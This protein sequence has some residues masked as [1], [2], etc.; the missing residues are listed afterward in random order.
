MERLLSRHDPL[1]NGPDLRVIFCFERFV[2]DF[3][4]F[5]FRF[6]PRYDPLGKSLLNV[7]SSLDVRINLLERGGVFCF[8]FGLR[9]ALKAVALPEY[10][11]DLV[12]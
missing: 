3:F 9:V 4:I 11:L 5:H 1:D 10:R 7:R 8:V 12:I 6:C 2:I